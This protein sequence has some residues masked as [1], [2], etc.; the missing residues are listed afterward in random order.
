MDLLQQAITTLDTA[1]ASLGPYDREEGTQAIKDACKT[2]HRIHKENPT[3]ASREA[4]TRATNILWY[5]TE[6]T[7]S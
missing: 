3:Q 5:F 6:Y 4:A 1:I 2:I 7:S